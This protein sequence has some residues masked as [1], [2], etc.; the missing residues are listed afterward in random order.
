MDK[1]TSE[2]GEQKCDWS[3]CK[4]VAGACRESIS[5]I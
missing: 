4:T 1:V 5:V 2:Q 3:K